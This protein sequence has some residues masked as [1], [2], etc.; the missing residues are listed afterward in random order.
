MTDKCVSLEL[1]PVMAALRFLSKVNPA[2][3]SRPPHHRISLHRTAWF[4]SSPESAP[5]GKGLKLSD[6]CVARLKE[7]TST[8]TDTNAQTYLRILVEGGGCSGFTYKFDLEDKSI[9]EEEDRVF[10]RE[11]AKVVIDETSLEYLHGNNP[12]EQF[13]GYPLS[14]ISVINVSSSFSF[15]LNR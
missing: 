2:I 10:E 5:V 6:S 8:E 13:I 11:G 14:F 4:S 9:D 1:C 12:F 3:L 7:I 15:R